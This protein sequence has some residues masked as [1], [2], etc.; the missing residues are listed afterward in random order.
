MTDS[1]AHRSAPASVDRS[2]EELA[3][4]T[5]NRMLRPHIWRSIVLLIIALLCLTLWMIGLT[6]SL[7][8]GLSTVGLQALILPADISATLTLLGVGGFLVFLLAWLAS[9][10]APV[11]EAVA[12]NNVLMPD[13]ADRDS[14]VFEAIRDTLAPRCPPLHLEE[15]KL[16]GLPSLYLSNGIEWA[17]VLV[18]PVGP[19]LHVSW[20]M[21]RSRST[22]S[23]VARTLS[24]MF[25][26]NRSD[27][28][29][30]PKA[31]SCSAMR[32]LLQLATRR[33]TA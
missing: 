24:D 33:A 8:Q 31:S 17:V 23:L 11:R 19:D 22:M 20:T 13:A 32:Q 27:H 18:R 1:A 29:M 16:D 26:G 6:S 30:L 5:G 25:D 4:F 9:L 7:L 3:D 28:P 21:W 2:E 15:E 12:E 14:A 10:W